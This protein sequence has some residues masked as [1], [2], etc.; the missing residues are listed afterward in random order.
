MHIVIIGGGLVG[1]AAA[2]E[3]AANNHRVTLIE[4]S[5]PEPTGEAWDLRISSVHL[6]NVDWLRELGIWQR[7]PCH[8][9]RSYTS[10]AVQSLDQQQVSF[11]ATEVGTGTL[12]AMV[13]NN[14]LQYAMWQQLAEHPLVTCIT[15][16]TLVSVDWSQQLAKLDN[17]DSIVFDLLLGA[18]GAFSSVAT[19]AAIST[20]GWD[21]DMRCLLA[22]VTTE[23]PVAPATWENFRPCGPYALLPL[24]DHQACLI[25]Y[26][27]NQTWTALEAA[28]KTQVR[29]ELQKV[30][31]PR[32]G[33]FTVQRAAS[34][35][36]RRQRALRYYAHDCVALIG[37]AAHSIH[38]LAGQGVNL[39]FGDVQQLMKS[40]QQPH[41]PTALADY[42]RQRLA[43]NQ[44]MMRA[45]DAIHL[46]FRSRHL[47]P[48]AA[49]GLSLAL[50][51][52]VAPLKRRI[53]RA[54]MGE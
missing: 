6:Q 43:V 16:A 1:A 37:D 24:D 38:P 52:R 3:A 20:R 7:V 31:A 42:Q 39:G 18:D 22:V 40:L 53:I 13:E 8:R 29:N 21:Y 28:G 35:P 9:Q 26:R 48:R 11:T 15:G 27:S 10:L 17:D 14:A 23:K 34:F 50:T 32:V 5:A 44:R 25:D 54:A 49:V 45:M 30:F 36:L 19:M 12:G 33:P 46:G 51:A 2:A 4:R 41:L 47:L